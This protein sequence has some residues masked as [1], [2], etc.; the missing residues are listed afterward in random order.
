VICVLIAVGCAGLIWWEGSREETAPCDSVLLRQ[1]DS[2]DRGRG[3]G[4]HA[5]PADGA[6][7][8]V[9]VPGSPAETT[10]QPESMPVDLSAS[11]NDLH[12]R[13]VTEDGVPIAGALVKVG[14]SKDR[15]YPLDSIDYDAFV[16]VAEALTAADGA[17]M[18]RLSDTRPHDVIATAR[19]YG[20]VVLTDR[21]A[22]SFVIVTM[23]KSSLVRGLVRRRQDRAPVR[24]ARID[25]W[26]LSDGAP[27]GTTTTDS[28]GRYECLDLDPAEVVIEVS[29][30]RE[31]PPALRTVM[32]R[33]G[34][35][36]Y[37]EDLLDEG[38]TISGRVVDAVTLVPI[39][40][41]KIGERWS[42][43]RPVWSGPGGTFHKPGIG[44]DPE[45]HV[46][47]RAYGRQVVRIS[48]LTAPQT[49]VTVALTKGRTIRGRAITATGQPIDGAHVAAVGGMSHH[50]AE[51]L[52][53]RNA[54]T[55]LDGR[56][57]L[58]GVRRDLR[59]ALLIRRPGFGTRI[60]DLPERERDEDP[61][62][63]GDVILREGGAIEGVVKDSANGVR[64]NAS[65]IASRIDDDRFGLLD[66][67]DRRAPVTDLYT[68]LIRVKTDD[69]G[70]FKVPDLSPGEYVVELAERPG[71]GTRVIVK[72]GSVVTGLII[73]ARY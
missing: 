1:S 40:G 41:A 8:T 48:R 20:S 21:H 59:H 31:V 17:F 22:G 10:V 54:M 39:E 36:H 58:V 14:V 71:N 5:R 43:G 12:G 25:I 50:S 13:A 65:I 27:I 67:S 49:N 61:I 6:G 52:D 19:A 66:K 16:P 45:L 47:A 69:R 46:V 42:L 2:H 55:D 32:L 57:E 44:A 28:S 3:D 24:E 9:I 7:R 60:S 30:D 63:V 29:P 18:F 62:D 26:R 23:R 51:Y 68:S 72:D 53:W 38:I 56:F 73:L 34:E 64:P 35:E 70:I 37:F 4:G 15:R 33:S 11:V